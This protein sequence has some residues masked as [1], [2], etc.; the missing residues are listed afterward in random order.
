M[1]L[2]LTLLAIFCFVAF[3]GAP[4]MAACYGTNKKTKQRQ[5]VHEIHR[6]S[7]HPQRHFAHAT[8]DPRTGRPQIIY[9]RRYSN[10]PSYFRRFVRHH[11]CCHHLGY[12]NEIA[13]NCC[14]IKRMRLSASGVAALRNYIVSRDV[15]SQTKVDRKGQGSTFWNKT[16]KQC[17]LNIR[18]D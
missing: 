12:R 13:A 10:A 16:S 1:R 7:Y 3:T 4:A 9:F 11:E 5:A 2:G 8:H 14:A 17:G 15:N 18:I 6:G